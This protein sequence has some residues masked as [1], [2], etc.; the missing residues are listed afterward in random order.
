M[1]KTLFAALALVAM[2][3]CSNEE[4][5]EMAQKE[6]I[7]FDNAFVNN[8]TR[9]TI[10]PSYTEDNMFVDFGVYGFVEGSTLFNNVRVSEGITNAD[11]K[12]TTWKYE[13]TQYWIAGAK[14]NF[15]AIAPQ[16]N[17]IWT[18]SS[19]AKDAITMSVT[20]T[21]VQDVLFAKTAE[22]EGLASGN[23]AVAFTFKHILSKV[24][25]SFENAYNA[26]NA[27]I[28]VKGIK[29]T[30]AHQT[31]TV[32]LNDNITWG[33]PTGT[34]ELD[35]GNATTDGATSADAVAYKYNETKESYK[36]L[37]LIPGAVTDGYN[38]TF[39]VELYIGEGVNPV[40]TYNHTAIVDFTPAAGN[41]YDIL[42]VINAENIDPNNTQEP[43]E[44]T[45]NTLPGW[46][47]TNNVKGDD[48]TI[49]NN[50]N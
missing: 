37:F 20:N 29:I 41:S 40:K 24:K 18:P 9:S 49:E 3:S 2:A 19:A 39:T 38:V 27:S 43:I 16:T 48:V 11:L 22:I 31:C 7:G 26:S 33:T 12:K 42:A 14:Y 30:N 8:S 1:K 13:G 45:V 34:L 47:D 4:V 10:D 44:F 32:T 21:G 15:A 23:P 25:F 46:G 50:K 36:E 35:F 28:K 6:A 17:A 5:L